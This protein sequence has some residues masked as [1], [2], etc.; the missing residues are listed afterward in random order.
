MATL[1]VP[2]VLGLSSRAR[3]GERNQ[4]V[5]TVS[6]EPR[7]RGKDPQPSVDRK[8][9]GAKSFGAGTEK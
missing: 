2:T 1:N 9:L 8:A 6:R 7:T 5:F 4:S 3:L